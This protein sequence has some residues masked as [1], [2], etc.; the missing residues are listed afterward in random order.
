VGWERGVEIERERER[1]FVC[2]W[3]RE[4]MSERRGWESVNEWVRERSKK[5]SAREEERYCICVY[6]GGRERKH[7]WERGDE[8]VWLSEWERGDERVW[9]SE[10]ER[11]DERVWLSE[12]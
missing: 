10:W 9:L 5:E 6:V 1:D 11:G 3:G 8:R 4:S 7:E 2:V 12:W